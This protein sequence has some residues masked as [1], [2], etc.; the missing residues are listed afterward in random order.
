MCR[1]N[2]KPV[3][4]NL[5]KETIGSKLS[6]NSNHLD[7]ISFLFQKLNDFY[8]ESIQMTNETNNTKK[9][10]IPVEKKPFT[11]IDQTDMFSIVFSI[12][13]TKSEDIGEDLAIAV[14]FEYIN[15]LHQHSIPIQYFIYELLINVLIREKR[16]YQLHQFLQY[17]VFTPCKPLACLLLSL[18]PHY[19]HATQLALDMFKELGVPPEDIIDIFLSQSDI[20]R[21]LRYVQSHGNMDSISARKFLEFAAAADD[22][23]VFYSVFK[24][25]EERN[26]RLRGS[27]S[28][29]KGK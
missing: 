4:L 3:I 23:Q 19:P 21:A 12:F 13:E 8:K 27:P 15:S 29:V 6:S 17:H 10:I 18:Q 25:F 20:F 22:P 16:Y 24:L 2:S 14:L 26:L 1:K 11:V 28:F 7:T 9:D 5:C